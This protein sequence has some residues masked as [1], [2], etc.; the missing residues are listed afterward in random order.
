METFTEYF[1]TNKV[2]L[3]TRFLSVRQG[4]HKVWN[5]HLNTILQEKTLYYFS[6]KTTVR[7]NYVNKQKRK[8]NNNNNNNNNN[9]CRRV[10]RK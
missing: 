4:G 7:I 8:G 6:W 9:K 10:E 2:Q 3:G 5:C 1:N